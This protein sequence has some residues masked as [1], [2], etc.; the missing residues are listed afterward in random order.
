[1]STGLSRNIHRIPRRFASRNG[2]FG[3][4][5]SVHLLD[6]A[7]RLGRAVGQPLADF[8][9]PGTVYLGLVQANL[10][11][12]AAFPFQLLNRSRLEF[13]TLHH[14]H[15]LYP[16]VGKI[17]VAYLQKERH[18]VSRGMVDRAGLLSLVMR[19]QE[20]LSPLGRSVGYVKYSAAAWAIW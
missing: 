10:E 7:L 4:M 9:G 19:C 8:G 6:T 3:G 5:A 18:L 11:V 1:M 17:V 2:S 14:Y 13:E 16:Q 20:S 15:V 12:V